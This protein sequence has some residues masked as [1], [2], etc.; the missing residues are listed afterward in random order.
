MVRVRVLYTKTEQSIA[1]A[2]L[3]NQSL[4]PHAEIYT[5]IGYDGTTQQEIQV[6]KMPFVVPAYF[7]YAIFSAG[8]ITK[9]G[10]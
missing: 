2:P 3:N 8:D 4:P 10:S 9:V 7:D 6:F 1:V 5:A